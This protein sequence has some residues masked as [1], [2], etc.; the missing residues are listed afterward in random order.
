MPEPKHYYPNVPGLGNVAVS[1]HAQERMDEYNIPQSVF[2][3][4]LLKPTREVEEGTDILWRERDQVRVVILQRPV[5]FHGAKLV[6]TVIRI[7]A[8][9]SARGR[10]RS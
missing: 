3:R 9:A 1:R 10:R 7:A 4:A 2:E 5:P 6:K 8:Q